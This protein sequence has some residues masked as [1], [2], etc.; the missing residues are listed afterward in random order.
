MMK[1]FILFCVVVNIISCGGEDKYKDIFIAQAIP[2]KASIVPTSAET[3]TDRYT[4]DDEGAKSASS[5]SITFNSF[6]LSWKETSRDLY[7]IKIELDLTNTVLATKVV[8]ADLTEI[9]NLFGVASNTSGKI[10]RAGGADA[11]KNS[12]NAY[13]TNFKEFITAGTM[14]PGEFA[15]TLAFGGIAV[16]EGLSLEVT[17]LIRVVAIAQDDNNNQEVIRTTTPVSLIIDSE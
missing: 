12:G 16:P 1:H 10:P 5:N 8:I 13:Y 14:D 2:S 11:T 17:G 9:G 3:C 4:L 15:C 7:I 6:G